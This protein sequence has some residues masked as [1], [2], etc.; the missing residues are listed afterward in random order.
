M[1]QQVSLMRSS[2]SV[3]A[4]I[5]SLLAEYAVDDAQSFVEGTASDG[6]PPELHDSYCQLL[7]NLR[8]YRPFLPDALFRGKNEEG[9]AK[10]EG[11]IGIDE[12]A[13]GE[14]EGEADAA[15]SFPDAVPDDD[16][17]RHPGMPSSLSLLLEGSSTHSAPLST[18][19]ATTVLSPKV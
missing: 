13:V 15:G 7:E 17:L 4:R 3:S 16:G 8:A 11:G 9:T 18:T 5:A 14:N 1:R 12:D 10:N 2:I 6:L 19:V